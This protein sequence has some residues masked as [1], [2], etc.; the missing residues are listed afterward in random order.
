MSLIALNYCH[1]DVFDVLYAG[2]VSKNLWALRHGGKLPAQTCFLDPWLHL[3]TTYHP[4]SGFNV[5][6]KLFHT[7]SSGIY[8]L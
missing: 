5:F 8:A 6:R 2:V 3:H 4:Q 1:C 7:I